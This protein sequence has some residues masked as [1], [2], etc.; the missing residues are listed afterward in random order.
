MIRIA[1]GSA[2]KGLKTAGHRRLTAAARAFTLHGAPSEELVEQ[3]LRA[4]RL[5]EAHRRWNR[6][7]QEALAPSAEWSAFTWH[8]LAHLVPAP[9][10]SRHKLAAPT[11]PGP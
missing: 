4:G 1:R 5:Q 3:H 10:R 7:L 2:P 11:R 6:L 9:Y 8:A